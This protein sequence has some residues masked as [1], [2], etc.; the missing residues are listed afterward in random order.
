MNMTETTTAAPKSAEAGSGPEPPP[1]GASVRGFRF[2]D[3][4]V[5][6]QDRSPAWV[7]V[8]R[9]YGRVPV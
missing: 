1:T 9:T 3:G 4:L 8:A 5:A 7:L 2:R 6:S